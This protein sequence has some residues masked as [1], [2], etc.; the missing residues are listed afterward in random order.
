MDSLPVSTQSRQ[1]FK[2]I[3]AQVNTWIAKRSM[4]NGF[5]HLHCPHTTAGLT[6]NEAADPDVA[7]DVITFLDGL[8][9]NQGLPGRAF[10]HA[11]GNSDA[12]V[13]SSLMG[14]SLT[15]PVEN[16]RLKLGTWQGVYFCEF[17]GPRQRQVWIGAMG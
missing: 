11:E 12:H 14:I 7:R 16:G 13:K 8:V 4:T 5:I 10:R 6:V 2:D 17:D 1:Q 15:L 9:P 3:T